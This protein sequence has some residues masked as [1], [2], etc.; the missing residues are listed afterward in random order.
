MATNKQPKTTR[1]SADVTAPQPTDPGDAPAD[2][3]DEK[4]RAISVRPDK[5]AAAAAGHKTVN[6]VVPGEPFQDAVPESQGRTETYTVYDNDNK[7]VQV[8]RDLDTGETTV[9]GEGDGVEGQAAGTFGITSINTAD[10]DEGSEL[11]DPAEHTVEAVLEYLN[12]LDDADQ[13]AYNAEVQRV[14]AAE[15]N[16]K[17]RKSLLDEIEPLNGS[18]G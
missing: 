18:G 6:A 16:G 15:Q 8:T 14:Y 2:T 4:E 1:L 13:E 10:N 12:G 7:P 5:A 17:A 3:F 9:T 11:F